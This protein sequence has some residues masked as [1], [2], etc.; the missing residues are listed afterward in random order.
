[1]FKNVFMNKVPSGIGD[2]SVKIPFFKLGDVGALLYLFAMNVGNFI[3]IASVLVGFG[4][5]VELV[6]GKVIP[7]ICVGLLFQGLYYSWMGYRLAQKE[8]RTDV[9]ALPFGLSTPAVFVFLFGVIL[10]LQHGLKLP[11]EQVWTAAI[12]ACFL[13]GIIEAFGGLIGPTLRKYLPRAAMLATVAGIA[14][15][16]MVTKGLFGVYSN[17]VFGMPILIIVLLG[18][19][20]GVLI[21][22]KIP[23]ILLAVV[24]ALAYGLMMGETSFNL[25]A[26]KGITLPQL[27]I[28]AVFSG[29]GLLYAFLAIIIP[30][31]IY[32]FIETMDNVEAAAAAGDDYNVAE[33]QLVDGGATMM[34]AMFGGIMPTSVWIGHVGFKKSGAGIGYTAAAGLLFAICGFFGLF[35]FLYYLMP[36][37]LFY[38][39][40]VWI[41]LLMIS[42][43]FVDTP[44][45]YTFAIGMALVPHLAN[46]VYTEVKM[47]LAS[48]HIYNLT[49][50]VQAA[51]SKAGVL[52]DGCAA[53]SHGSILSGMLWGSVMVFII[54]RQFKKASI[55]TFIAA[56]LAAIGLIHGARIGFDQI[57]NPFAVSY[58]IIACMLYAVH[59]FKDK[60]V[61]PMRHD[62]V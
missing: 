4:W 15:V 30:I 37:M 52:W 43:A 22:K 24:F 28:A 20:G 44:R 3:L 58:V 5:P 54:D 17:P 23:A 16:W 47:T 26:I 45:R 35:E 34:T 51:L 62:Y 55:M 53:L 57:A 33:A 40:Y 12:A 38:A 31:E 59:V 49:P 10:P 13:G 18:L 7:G 9:C 56:V 46:L 6:F 36:K 41:A 48:V 1:M 32:N 21:S 2:P 50:E 19:I 61:I 8:Q 27:D 39:L 14:M 42:Q 29:W 25:E 60:L 11:P